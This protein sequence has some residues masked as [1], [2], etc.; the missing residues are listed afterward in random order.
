MVERLLLKL[1]QFDKVS[2]EEEQALRAAVSGP[3][4]YTKGQTLNK[5]KTELGFSSLVTSGFVH[6]FNAVNDGSRQTVHLAVPGDFID[7]HSLLLKVVE[8]EVVALS[9]CRVVRFSHD[10]LTYITRKHDHLMRLLWLCLVIDEAIEAQAITS[11][12]IRS[13]ASRMAHFFCE[14]QVRLEAVR[15]APPRVGQCC[16][17]SLPISQEKISDV[18][19]LTPVHTNRM[20]KVLRERDLVTFKANHLVQICDWDGLA[21][22]AEFDPFYLGQRQLP[23]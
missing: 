19:G 18:L 14:L 2:S 5:A 1:R 22:L 15:L 17:Y 9:D 21:Q 20:L 8:H 12:G 13:A 4:T 11:L 3:I 10:A 7:L 16:T 23:R 6:S